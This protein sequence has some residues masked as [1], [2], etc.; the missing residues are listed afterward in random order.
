[1]SIRSLG[2]LIWETPQAEAWRSFGTDVLGMM[3]VDA[4]G[5]DATAFRTDDRPYRL[6]VRH[7]DPVDDDHHGEHS[8]D[9]VDVVD[10]VL[11]NYNYN[12]L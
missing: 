4:V 11:D 8:L 7:A 2:Y 3:A 5:T 12:Y 10:G 9:P 6:V 1:M